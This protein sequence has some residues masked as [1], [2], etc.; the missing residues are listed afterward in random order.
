MKRMV[1]LKQANEINYSQKGGK[2]KTGV[3]YLFFLGGL[4]LT[5]FFLG[6][7]PSKEHF[8]PRRLPHAFNS[9]NVTADDEKCNWRTQGSPACRYTAVLADVKLASP[10]NSPV[11]VPWLLSK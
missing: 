8:T 11:Q 9:F 7:I 5:I 10:F 6:N 1:S 3:G 2:I 4:G